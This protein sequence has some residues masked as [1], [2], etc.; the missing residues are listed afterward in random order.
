MSGVTALTGLGAEG[1]PIHKDSPNVF[2]MPIINPVSTPSTVISPAAATE[3]DKPSSYP[4]V[5]PMIQ[6]P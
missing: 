2:M 3:L 6:A 4:T 1:P 5:S